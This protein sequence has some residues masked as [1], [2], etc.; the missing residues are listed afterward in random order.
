MID[1]TTLEGADTAGKVRGAVRQGA[2]PRPERPA[3][4]RVRPPSASTATWSPTAK[5][6]LGSSGV[7]VAA[8]ATAFPSGRAQPAGQA[9]RHPRRGR[10]RRRRDRHGHRPRRVPVRRLPHGVPRDRRGPRP[11]SAGRPAPAQGDHGDRR[12]RHLRQRPP[13]LLAVDAGRRRLH[14]DLHRQDLA[15]RHPARSP[16]SCS[17]RCATGATSPARWSASS[18]PAASAPARTPSSSSSRV[19]EIAGEDWL[20]THWF[21]FGASSL[22]NDLLLQRQR[23]ATGAYSGADYVAD[24]SPSLY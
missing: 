3:A 18:R 1:L 23:M 4:P 7:K 19:S 15:R 9:R 21:R 12:A 14:Q 16:W 22:L 8:V 10:G 11:A 5:E 13:R 20:D 6:A 2:H 17:R 24:D